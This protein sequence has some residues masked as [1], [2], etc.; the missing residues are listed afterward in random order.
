[1]FDVMSIG[2]ALL[3]FVAPV[4]VDAG[5]ALVNRY[6]TPDAVKPANFGEALEIAKLDMERFKVLQEADKPADN[7][8]PIVGDIRALQRPM[9][10]FAVT[11]KWC[12]AP[13]NAALDFMVSSV[14]FYL[15]GERTLL[16]GRA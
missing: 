9:I 4:V 3:S 14:W 6:I 7:V 13:Q 16:K 11:L 1:M 12:V 15:F 2:T 10:A 8:S 5:K